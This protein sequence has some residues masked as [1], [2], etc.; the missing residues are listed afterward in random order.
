MCHGTSGKGDG[1]AGVNLDPKPKDHTSPVVQNQSD[2]ALFWKITT[3]KLPMASYEKSTN[4]R[5]ALA[6]N[7]LHK[8]T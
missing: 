4:K 6:S 5:A 3:G 1:P 7:P 8:D 2:G